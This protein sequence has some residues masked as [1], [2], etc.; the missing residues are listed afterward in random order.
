MAT[1]VVVIMQNTMAKLQK[2]CK[3]AKLCLWSKKVG[4]K[5][6]KIDLR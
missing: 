6:E 5:V 4:K 1:T 2:R 3:A